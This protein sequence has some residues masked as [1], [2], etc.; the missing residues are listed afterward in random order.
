MSAILTVKLVGI[1]LSVTRGLISPTAFLRGLH[2]SPEGEWGG[3]GL[4]EAGFWPAARHGAFPSAGHAASQQPAQGQCRP[5]CVCTKEGT[6][7]GHSGL[8]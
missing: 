6:E 2:G 3:L 4:H 7:G 1:Q 5:S 8:C